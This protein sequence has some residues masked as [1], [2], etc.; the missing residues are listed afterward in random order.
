MV[1]LEDSRQGYSLE[2]RRPNTFTPRFFEYVSVLTIRETELL[3]WVER[4]A[5]TVELEH[6]NKSGG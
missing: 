1:K 6:R 5:T 2:I 4:F 3:N